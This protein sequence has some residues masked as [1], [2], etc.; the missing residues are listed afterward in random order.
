[1]QVP[2]NWTYTVDL[3]CVHLAQGHQQAGISKWHRMKISLLIRKGWDL[4]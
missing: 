4:T 1:M 3:R 2:C